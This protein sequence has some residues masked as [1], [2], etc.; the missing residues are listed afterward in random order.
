[1]R[2]PLCCGGVIRLGRPYLVS[3]SPLGIVRCYTAGDC[4]SVLY[5]RAWNRTTQYRAATRRC[6]IS[7][8]DPIAMRIATQKLRASAPISVSWAHLI[9]GGNSPRTIVPHDPYRVCPFACQA[10]FVAASAPPLQQPLS[11]PDSL[12]LGQRNKPHRL[13]HK[14]SPRPVVI[15]IQ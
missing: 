9:M 4:Y 10:F 14:P 5:D 3:S 13:G 11:R 2:V 12:I 7:R 6:A 15:D 8:S 1:M